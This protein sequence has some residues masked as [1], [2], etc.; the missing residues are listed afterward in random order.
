M[1]FL[2]LLTYFFEF[3]WRFLCSLRFCAVPS[4][5]SFFEFIWRFLCSLRFLERFLLRLAKLILSRLR[6]AFSSSLS[7]GL[8]ANLVMGAPSCVCVPAPESSQAVFWTFSSTFD[9]SW[10]LPS[11]F[12]WLSLPP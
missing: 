10:F 6:I 2:P 12:A 8:T 9:W 7:S 3:F 1:C 5:A 11:A 4:S